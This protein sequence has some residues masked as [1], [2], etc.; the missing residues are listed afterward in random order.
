M[1]LPL[2]LEFRN[3]GHDSEEGTRYR[4]AAFSPITT[5]RGPLILGMV[6][7]KMYTVTEYLKQLEREYGKTFHTYKVTV[8]NT[9][10][11]TTYIEPRT[12]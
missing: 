3:N 6:S 5:R 4:I 2:H 11:S 10:Y 7:G 9:G 1:S 8:A 12:N